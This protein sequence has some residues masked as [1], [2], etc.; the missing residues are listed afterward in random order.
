[1]RNAGL[2]IEVLIEYL[3]LFRQGDATIEARKALLTEQRDQLIARIGEMQ[4]TLERLNY[5]IESYEQTIVPAE[6]ELVKCLWSNKNVHTKATSRI[7]S[8]D[9]TMRILEGS[10]V[11]KGH[12]GERTGNEGSRDELR[13]DRSSAR[14]RPKDREE[15][16]HDGGHPRAGGEGEVLHHRPLCRGHRR[17]A[18]EAALA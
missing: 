13:G 9:V 15:A 3:A 17:V 11:R 8:G 14:H 4:K 5:K 16:L 1:M 10:D 2:R 12:L 6:N 18:R 7:P